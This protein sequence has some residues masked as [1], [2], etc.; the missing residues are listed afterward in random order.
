MDALKQAHPDYDP[1]NPQD[2]HAW[3]RTEA[4]REF[5]RYLGRETATDFVY[6]GTGTNVERYVSWINAAH[7]AGYQVEMVYVTCDL[8]T[9]LHRNANRDRVV[10]EDVVRAKHA[11]V[12]TAFEILSRYADSVRVVNNN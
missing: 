4:T 12:G 3:S 8:A 1:K 11:T 6:D 10:P 7:D 2:L 9:A 5:F